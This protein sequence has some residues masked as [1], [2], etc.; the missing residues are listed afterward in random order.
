[1]TRSGGDPGQFGS[2]AKRATTGNGLPQD[3]AERAKIDIL[4]AT[5]GLGGIR[6]LCAPT[7][8]GRY[9]RIPAV[10]SGFC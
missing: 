3:V 4:R 2:S 7:T 9:L 5:C 1:M 10:P 6:G 8:N